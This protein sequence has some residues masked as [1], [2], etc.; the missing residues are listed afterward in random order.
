MSEDSFEK[1]PPQPSKFETHGLI[2]THIPIYKILSL[3]VQS[4]HWSMWQEIRST[5]ASTQ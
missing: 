2:T 1:S 5:R 3:W 4:Q